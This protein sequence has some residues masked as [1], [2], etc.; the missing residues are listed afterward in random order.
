MPTN[1]T[2]L[3]NYLIWFCK[4]D[5]KWISPLR[6]LK[7]K[8]RVIEQAINTSDGSKVMPD[9][10]LGSDKFGHALV[11]ECKGGSTISE[12]QSAKYKKLTAKD[13]SR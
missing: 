5:P 2:I 6:A 1:H 10:I 11:C 4:K 7:Y 8:P 3:I 9:I 13:L 12:E